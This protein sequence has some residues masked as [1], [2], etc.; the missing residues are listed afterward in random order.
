MVQK[1]DSFLK[2]INGFVPDYLSSLLPEIRE[3]RY[4]LRNTHS[5]E[6][7]KRRT[8]AFGNSFFSHH[9]NEW[10]NLGLEFSE[11]RSLS[12]FKTKL[13]RL[14]R[15]V[16][17]QLYGIHDQSGVCRLT[18]LRLGLSLLGLTLP[19]FADS[20]DKFEPRS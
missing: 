15:P 19:F 3:Q 6:A 5:F 7:P 18:Q 12:L 20:R 11:V 13:I 9:I 16:K 4:D 17:G 10:N 8:D 1:T 2:I 14:V